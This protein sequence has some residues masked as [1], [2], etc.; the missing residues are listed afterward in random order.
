MSTHPNQ[1]LYID[2]Q[3]VIRFK[4]NNRVVYLLENGGI[5]LNHLAVMEFSQEDRMQFAQLTGYSLGG[6]G[7]LS[8]VTDDNYELVYATKGGTDEQDAELIYLR[9]K[10]DSIREQLRV[11]V[12]LAFRIDP[13]DLVE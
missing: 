10:L 5:D 11:L 7:D 6:Y 9:E 4:E 2:Q 1:P 8:F 12:P 13:E 3:G